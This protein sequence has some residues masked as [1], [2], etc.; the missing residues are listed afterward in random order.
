MDQ[1]V[2]GDFVS[3]PGLHPLVELAGSG[4][5]GEFVGARRSHA[6]STGE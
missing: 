1:K 6:R 4:E 5:R 3:R 2:A